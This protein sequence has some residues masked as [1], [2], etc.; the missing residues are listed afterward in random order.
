MPKWV[1]FVL[2][3]DCSG[4]CGKV[5]D[6]ANGPIF[7]SGAHDKSRRQGGSFSYLIFVTDTTDMSV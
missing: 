7:L 6:I 3:Q 1:N 5:L 2:K 4:A